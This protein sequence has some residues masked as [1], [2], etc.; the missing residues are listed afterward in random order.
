[1]LKMLRTIKNCKNRIK[2]KWRQSIIETRR[3]SKLSRKMKKLTLGFYL[4]VLSG[5]GI[6]IIVI[7]M[8]KVVPMLIQI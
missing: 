5:P 6:P 3:V 2:S 1:M 8:L 4:E 7:S